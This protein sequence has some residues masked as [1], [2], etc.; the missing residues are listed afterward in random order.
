MFQPIPASQIGFAD[1]WMSNHQ[2]RL[3]GQNMKV[4]PLL[5][6]IAWV[7][8][9]YLFYVL[10]GGACFMAIERSVA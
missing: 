4:L 6:D 5:K 9:M 7:F 3:R 1:M 10:I 8:G 2:A